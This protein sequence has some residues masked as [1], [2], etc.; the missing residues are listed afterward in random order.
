VAHQ[1][2]ASLL[3]DAIGGEMTGQLA[4]AAPY[5]STILLYSKLSQE[6]CRVDPAVALVKNLCLQ[7]W[8]LANWVKTKNLLQ[9]L[10][11][12]R[13]A[14]RLLA[15]DLSSHVGQRVPLSAAQEALSKYVAAM[16]HQKVL[17]RMNDGS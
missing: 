8:F 15:T 5:G 3:L 11:L 17:F 9:T 7:G 10:A 4:E 14:Q 2:E 13:T 6:D 1:L 12:S 16:T